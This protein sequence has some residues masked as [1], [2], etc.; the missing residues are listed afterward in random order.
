[1]ESVIFGTYVVV[2]EHE[3][4]LSQAPILGLILR[5]SM[6]L[7]LTLQEKQSNKEYLTTYRVSAVKVTVINGDVWCKQI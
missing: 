4:M 1:M 7:K 6:N 2:V 3:L 5:V